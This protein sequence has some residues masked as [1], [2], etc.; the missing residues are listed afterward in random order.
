MVT[1]ATIGYELATPRTLVDALLKAKI[2]ILVDVRAVPNSRRP[3]FSKKALTAATAEA[4]IDYLHLRG[5]GTPADGRVAA[6]AGRHAEM[7][8]IFREQL[9]TLEAR[10]DLY[11]LAELIREKRRACLLC[12]EASAEHCH[13]TLVA[14]AVQQQVAVTIRDLHPEIATPAMVAERRSN[15][16]PISRTKPA[17][18][19]PSR[20]TKAGKAEGAAAARMIDARI[21]ELG[22]WRGKMLADLRAVIRQADPAV[23]EEW[24]WAVPV[25]SHQGV[26]CTGESYKS[27]VKLTFARG[28]SLE[29]P[30]GLFNSSLDGN[31]RRAIDFRE[32]DKINKVALKALVREAVVLNS[33]RER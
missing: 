32:G 20:S 18:P 10:D 13:R 25:W 7:H 21:K 9:K 8:A 14:R 3:G 6:R 5:L 17:K 4:G 24:K 22:D 11:L 15:P 16:M 33:S 29:D 12:L 19:A 26:I 30:T 27:V 23:V 2:D 1:L 28:A 31:T